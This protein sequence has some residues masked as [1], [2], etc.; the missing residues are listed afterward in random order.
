MRAWN[1]YAIEI[2]FAWQLQVPV[3]LSALVR[4]VKFALHSQLRSQ[5]ALKSNCFHR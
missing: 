5:P 2:M 4:L 3:E 1:K